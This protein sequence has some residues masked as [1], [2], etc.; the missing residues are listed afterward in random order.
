MLQWTREWGRAQEL[1]WRLAILYAEEFHKLNEPMPAVK[2]WLQALQKANVPCALIS[3]MPAAEV[4]VQGPPG[5]LGF[6]LAPS[7]RGDGRRGRIAITKAVQDPEMTRE[8]GQRIG[9]SAKQCCVSLWHSSRG[10]ELEQVM[11]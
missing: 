5:A 3:Q 1:A 10:G 7:P 2:P 11:Y 6:R 9:F 8:E 4:K